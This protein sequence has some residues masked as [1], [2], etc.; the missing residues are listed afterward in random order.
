MS[1]SSSFFPLPSSCS[2]SLSF[3]LLFCIISGWGGRR[4]K[5]RLVFF[6]ESMVYMS[7][8][9]LLTENLFFSWVTGGCC[10]VF[11]LFDLEKGLS[12]VRGGSL[13]CIS[14]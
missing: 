4:G 3:T 10:F 8:V 11:F 7:M 2:R 13:R 6:V 5:G 12:R 14:C 9:Y 1:I